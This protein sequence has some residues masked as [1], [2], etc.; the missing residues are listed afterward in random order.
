MHRARLELVMRLLCARHEHVVPL[1]ANAQGGAAQARV[2]G[3]VLLAEWRLGTRLL[4]LVAN[5]SDR[6]AKCPPT[7]AATPIWGGLPP[8]R[9]PAWSVYWSLGDG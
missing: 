3:T 2:A 7:R 1:L 4:S 5:L 8:P 9:L 6:P